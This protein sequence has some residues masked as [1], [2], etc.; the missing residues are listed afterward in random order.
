MVE[1]YYFYDTLKN[2]I[3][4]LNKNYKI[5]LLSVTSSG[6]SSLKPVP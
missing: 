1:K 4:Y 2:R 6:T 3:D 5:G